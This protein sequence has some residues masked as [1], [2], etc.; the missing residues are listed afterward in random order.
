MR[1]VPPTIFDDP[2]RELAN[3]ILYLTKEEAARRHILAAVQ[4]WHDGDFD[5]AITLAGA[6]DRM[7]KGVAM[8][9][10]FRKIIEARPPEIDEKTAANNVNSARNWLKHETNY[11]PSTR[12]FIFLDS[13]LHILM[14]ADKWGFN[15]EPA[16][17]TLTSVWHFMLDFTVRDGDLQELVQRVR[18]L[19]LGVAI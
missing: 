4:R 3:T 18:A 1:D 7:T 15:D 6:A 17:Q 13:G 9:T 12:S 16:V 10:L 11:M 14:A 8:D 5:L 19:E 2:V